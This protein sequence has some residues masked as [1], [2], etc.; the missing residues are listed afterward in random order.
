MYVWWN[1][2][3]NRF[4]S[5][6]WVC[7]TAS[8][9]SSSYDALLELFECLGNFLKRLEIYT[10]IPPTPIMTD[11]V[12]KIMVELLSVL[13][14]ATK[15]IRQGRFSK[16]AVIYTLPVANCSTEKFA[17]KLLGDSEIE[18]VLHRLDRLTQDEAR[19]TAAQTLGVVHGLVGNM[20]VVMEGTERLRGCSGVFLMICFFR[21]QGVNRWYSTRPGY[22]SGAEQVS[23]VLTCVRSRSP[24]S[25]KRNKQDETFVVLFYLSLLKPIVWL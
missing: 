24:P 13:A 3:S 1:I 11:I 16:C 22:V 8:G 14:L 20:K 5:N 10:T 2:S 18:S 23:S 12:I 19:I 25:V 17:K 7:Q 21:W 15:Q 9:V 6:A 4:P